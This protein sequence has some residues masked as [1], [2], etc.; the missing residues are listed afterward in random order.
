MRSGVEVR[1]SMPLT[2]TTRGQA[3]AM[4]VVYDSP[5]QMVSDDPSNYRGETGF[6]FV[7][8]VPAAWDETRFLAGEPFA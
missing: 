4:Y 6:D 8:R 2:Q 1:A 3:L 5:L 7:R